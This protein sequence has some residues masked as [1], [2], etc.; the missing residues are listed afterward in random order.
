MSSLYECAADCC[1]VQAMRGLCGGSIIQISLFLVKFEMECPPSKISNFSP[2]NIFGRTL[3][4][5][6]IHPPPSCDRS[7]ASR[8]FKTLIV[9]P[10]RAN[11]ALTRS[12][13]ILSERSFVSLE[14]NGEH[15][16]ES[17]LRQPAT[18]RRFI[19]GGR[20]S[21]QGGGS[22]DDEDDGGGS[23]GVGE[24]RKIGSVTVEEER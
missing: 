4:F 15:S 22:V 21:R 3:F 1:R 9:M 17:V 19:G 7:R 11:T 12:A 5:P 24:G 20:S 16:L 18:R 13:V 14:T 8:V 2:H 6:R 23:N 10:T